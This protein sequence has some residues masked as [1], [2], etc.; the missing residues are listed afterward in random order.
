MTETAA[1]IV[2][3][4]Y[5]CTC[6]KHFDLDFRQDNRIHG[7]VKRAHSCA[8]HPVDRPYF[9]FIFQKNLTPLASTIS[10]VPAIGWLAKMAKSRNDRK[11]V[12]RDNRRSSNVGGRN[13][14]CSGFPPIHRKSPNRE[15]DRILLFSPSGSSCDPVKKET[16]SPKT[17]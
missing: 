11:V 15:I 8:G 16:H 4:F 5:S 3:W 12:F 6:L 9:F 13:I 7:I 10:F 2:Q 1:S 14:A 17:D